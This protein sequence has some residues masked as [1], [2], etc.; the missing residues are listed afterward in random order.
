[1][2]TQKLEEIQEFK[3][4]F[5]DEFLL[6]YYRLMSKFTQFKRSFSK[7]YSASQGRRTLQMGRF[8]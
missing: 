5:R 4:T 7:K 8:A 3:I 6:E 2:S 1:M